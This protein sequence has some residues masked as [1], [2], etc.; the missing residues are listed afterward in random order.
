M[1]HDSSSPFGPLPVEATGVA[2]QD[3]IIVVVGTV[4]GQDYSRARAW[5]SAD[6]RTWSKASVE[7]A[8]GALSRS[9]AATPR[10][11][12]AVGGSRGCPGGIWASTDGRAWRCDLAD[13]RA[14]GFG[15]DAVAGSD[16]VDVAVGSTEPGDG[17]ASVGS[18]SVIWSRPFR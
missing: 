17:D 15:P 12:L 9:V 10:G 3:G 5:W 7:A 16:T 6:G 11:F 1:F 14:S 8:D 4:E 13:P 2:A 18:S